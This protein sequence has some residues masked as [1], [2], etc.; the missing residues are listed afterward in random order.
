MCIRDSKNTKTNDIT[1]NKF[2]VFD[3]IILKKGIATFD[4]LGSSSI[5]S[6]KYREK[7]K[8]F[9]GEGEE[10]MIDGI[11]NLDSQDTEPVSILLKPDPDNIGTYVGMGL[12]NHNMKKS[13]K[14][15]IKAILVPIN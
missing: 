11:F 10:I 7:I 13:K 15:Y 6:N 3:K 1:K 8:F 12:W 9:Q 14:E 5:I 2:I 4:K